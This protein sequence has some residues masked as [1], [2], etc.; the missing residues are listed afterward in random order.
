[1]RERGEG[2]WKRVGGTDRKGGIK[3]GKEEERS[4]EEDLG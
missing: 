2:R 3:K 4:K 1:M